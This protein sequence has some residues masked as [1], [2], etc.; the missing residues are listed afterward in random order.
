MKER[1]LEPGDK[2]YGEHHLWVG[3]HELAGCDQLDLG[4]SASVGW[5]NQK[6]F[7]IC[8]SWIACEGKLHR[9]NNGE[10]ELNPGKP[11]KQWW[12]K[13]WGSSPSA[14]S[15]PGPVETSG[16]QSR[17]KGKGKGKGKNKGT[18]NAASPGAVVPPAPTS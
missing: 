18:K 8:G 7:V 17:P 6:F 14:V 5:S 13:P 9:K 1:K 10:R 12:C 4:D 16:D 2:V 11:R 15:P 3:V